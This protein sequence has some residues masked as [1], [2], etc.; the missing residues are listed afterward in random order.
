MYLEEVFKWT[1]KFHSSGYFLWQCRS[2]S[3]LLTPGRSTKSASTLHRNGTRGKR[4]HVPC[5]KSYN[6]TEAQFAYMCVIRFFFVSYKQCT[7]LVQNLDNDDEQEEKHVIH[8]ASNDIVMLTY[9]LL[10]LCL[11]FLY[12]ITP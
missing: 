6:L 7:F 12:E 4:V 3:R 9:F 11:F 5:Y 10:I 1:L 2:L 8:A